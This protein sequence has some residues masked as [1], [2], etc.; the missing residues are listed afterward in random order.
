MT[1]EA[2]ETSAILTVQSLCGQT[3]VTIPGE[4]PPIRLREAAAAPLNLGAHHPP[5][6][7]RFRAAK[8]MSCAKKTSPLRPCA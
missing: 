8:I 2:L 6:R 7:C 1:V 3:L 5:F 4:A